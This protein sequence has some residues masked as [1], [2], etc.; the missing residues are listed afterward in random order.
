MDKHLQRLMRLAHP[1]PVRLSPDQLAWL[2]SWRGDTMPRAAAIRVLLEQAMRLHRD[3]LLP[4]TGYRE[5][6]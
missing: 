3:G 6:A 5:Q 4:A 2:D 1:T